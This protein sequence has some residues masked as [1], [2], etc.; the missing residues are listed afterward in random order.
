MNTKSSITRRSFIQSTALASAALAAPNIVTA[1]RGGKQLVVGEGAHAY[2]VQHDWVTLPDQFRW[3]T[4]HNV[5]FDT[6]GLLYVI[7]E[8]RKSQPDHPSIFVF[9]DKG[10]Y[11]RSFG[12]QFQGGGHGLEVRTEGAEQFLYVTGYQQLKNFAK[13]TLTGEP[14]WEKRAP[15]DSNLYK[16]G[17]DTHPEQRWGRDAFMPTNFAFHDDGGFYLA[18]GYGSHTIHRYDKDGNWMFYF[19][20][21]GKADGEFNL[22]HGI[23]IDD[24]PGRDKTLV[25]ADRAN[26]RL[27]WFTLAGKHIKTMDGFILPA[28]V[29][30]YEDVL[31]V[32]DLSARVT[33]I[34]KNNTLIH[35]GDD[36]AWRAQVV[37]DGNKLRR[38]PNGE[39]WRSGRF[40]H[41]HDA[42]FDA[43]GNIIVAEWVDTGRITRLRKLS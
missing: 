20:K 17:E 43:N 2:E 22:P 41:P 1:A 32:P 34:D 27:Q 11:V 35:L 21:P 5:A 9:D 7:H 40:L 31:L 16:K 37:A 3:Q 26:N 36:P 29:D 8:G 12:S 19:G 14:V 33:L 30:R 6:E 13:L 15:M 18:D 42:C 39:G 24:R 25:V 10:K 38:Q 28:N 4:T 23:W